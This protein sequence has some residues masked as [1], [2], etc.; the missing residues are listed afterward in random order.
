[1]RFF[2]SDYIPR[3]LDLLSILKS[4]SCFLFGPRQTGKSSMIRATIGDHP[5]YSLLDSQTYLMLSQ[6]LKWI[7]QTLRPDT[8][9]VVIDE[10]QKLP[11]LLDEIHLMIEKYNVRFLMTGSSTR[12]LRRGGVN[13]L[14]GRARSRTLH[15]LTYSELGTHF[16]LLRALSRG[17]I[18]SIYFSD[19]PQEDLAA[20]CGDYLKEEISSEALVRNIP[21]FSRFLEVAALC[22]GQIINYT[23]ISND[24]RV[25]QSTVQ[26]Y[27]QIL[28]DTLIGFE[29]PAWKKTIKRKPI[30]TSKFYFF[31]VGVARYLQHQHTLAVKSPEFGSAL[32][33]YIAHEIKSWVDLSGTGTLHYWRTTSGYEV[34]F[35]V[36]E[37][38]AIEV[39]AKDTISSKDLKG[40]LALKEESNLDDYIVVSLE[41]VAREVDGVRILPWQVFLSE[42]LK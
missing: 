17:L 11:E 23:N 22:N 3:R 15:P 4:K 40:L 42:V 18:P 2:E 41:T 36:N 24:A 25:P 5:F 21:S 33:H 6:N 26:N 20:Y 7:E 39:K 34:D 1:M 8:T 10:I 38:I 30:Q 29:V 31:D 9:I 37:S 12:S 28:I 27:F 16:D 19:S 32:E 13:L 14:G 35:I